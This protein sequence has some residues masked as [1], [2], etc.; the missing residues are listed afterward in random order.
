M[1]VY[2]NCLFQELSN[3]VTDIAIEGSA[4]TI[5][6]LYEEC[7]SAEAWDVSEIEAYKRCTNALAKSSNQINNAICE[8]QEVAKRNH[9]GLS[10]DLWLTMEEMDFEQRELESNELE[11]TIIKIKKMAGLCDKVDFEP[12]EECDKKLEKTI[13]K[14]KKMEGTCNKGKFE[15]TEEC[16]EECLIAMR[17]I[18]LQLKLIQWGYYGP[19]ETTLG[20][21]IAYHRKTL[22]GYFENSLNNSWPYQPLHRD[23][24]NLEIQLN[25]YMTKMTETISGTLTDISILDLPA[26]GSH[27]AN[28]DKIQQSESNWPNELNFA[29]YNKF[30][31]ST[32]RMEAFSQYKRLIGLWQLYL[33]NVNEHGNESSSNFPPCLEDNPFNFTQ[34]IKKDFSTFLKVY[35]GSYPTALT[36]SSDVWSETAKDIFDQTLKPSLIEKIGLYDKVIMDCSFKEK[37]MKRASAATTLSGGCKYFERTLTSNG[38]C[39][40]FNGLGPSNI[41]RNSTVVQAFDETFSTTYSSYDFGGT[42]SNEGTWA[43]VSFFL[44]FDSQ[45]NLMN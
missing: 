14:I 44:S 29:I 38:F 42:G 19:T 36:K 45:Y 41:W 32:E 4:N 7:S 18:T 26:F 27:I 35:E 22:G 34:Y 21:Y 31:T 13:N 3:K 5:K 43:Q 28:L 11:K 40:S 10:S 1:Y 30:K 25:E 15:P 20:N 8:I 33:E 17:N 39:Y 6:N 2:R 12:T 16:N 23:P 37:L 9:S 24:N